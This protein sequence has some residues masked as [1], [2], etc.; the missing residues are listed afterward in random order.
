MNKNIIVTGGAGFIGSH[1]CSYLLEEGHQITCI[2]NLSTGNIIN[3]KKLRNNR[4]FKFVNSDI[5]ESSSDLD[6]LTSIQEIYHLASPAS[7]PYIMQHPI[8][9]AKANSLGTMRL[10]ELAM[11]YKARLLFASSSE[12]YGE[13]AVHPQKESYW[14]NVNPVGFRSGY[15]E[16]KRFGEAMCMAYYR[17]KKCNVKI[18]RIFNTYGPN[19]SARDSR[20]VPTFIVQSLKGLPL[21]VHGDGSQ[22]RSLCFVSDL[23]DGL[24]KMMN[25]QEVGPINLGNP[26][27][28][29]VIDLASKI[30]EMTGS[31][32]PIS[33]TK[34]PQDDPTRRK[35]DIAAAEKLLDWKPQVGLDQGLMQTI[36]YFKTLV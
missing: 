10:L 36:E 13:P 33:F 6:N 27:E 35:P 19:S 20:V 1:L 22:T 8:A 5:A 7:V 34:R 3:I 2:D 25:S 26:Y 21:T 14:G 24:V 23:V 11:K 9:A 30:I 31:S 28:I 4:S 12:T 17:E 15:D 29:K 18:V 32:S 16:G